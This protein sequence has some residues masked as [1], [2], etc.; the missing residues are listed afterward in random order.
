MHS[1]SV[2]RPIATGAIAFLILPGSR[3]VARPHT[4][5]PGRS[6]PGRRLKRTRRAPFVAWAACLN[7]L[8]SRPIVGKFARGRRFGGGQKPE[9]ARVV[10][11]RPE[12]Q[13]E[14]WHASDTWAGPIGCA[15][16]R[17]GGVSA[18]R[19]AGAEARRHL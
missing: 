5:R 8:R 11:P 3:L 16:D 6:V 12:A 14:D 4:R 19:G 17:R 7:S 10:A 1:A 2:A 13:R 9:R 15:V 18:G